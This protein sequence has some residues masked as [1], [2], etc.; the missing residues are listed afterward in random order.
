MW[1]AGDGGSRLIQTLNRKLEGEVFVPKGFMTTTYIDSARRTIVLS[2]PAK[3]N[4]LL[5]RMGIINFVK[6]VSEIDEFTYAT[7]RTITQNASLSI[8][9]MKEQLRTPSR[10]R[11]LSAFR[12][13]AP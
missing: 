2:H 4:V 7:A 12:A 3:R 8:A 11:I 10:Q 5:E 9:V 6:P 13:C 1:G